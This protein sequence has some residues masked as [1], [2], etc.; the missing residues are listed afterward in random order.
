MEMRYLKYC[1]SCKRDRDAT[2]FCKASDRGDGL[3]GQCKSCAREA[4]NTKISLAHRLHYNQTNKSIERGYALPAY[5]RDEL[6]SWLM[7]QELFH[8][9]HSEWKQSGY[10]KML[11]PSVD[12]LDDYVSYEFNNIQLMT[13]EENKTKGHLD[14]RNK[15][16]T[17]THSTVIQYTKDGVFVA[18][19]VGMKTAYQ[20]TG[21]RNGNISD[22]CNGKRKTA[23][24]YIWRLK[25]DKV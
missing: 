21:V 11:T 9:L 1:P 23:G 6:Y 10:K 4:R 14:R 5:S 24:G 25:G 20:M 15:V 8:T 2:K 16:N 7:S 12:R 17:K 18:E 13:W 19:F 3:N 22:V